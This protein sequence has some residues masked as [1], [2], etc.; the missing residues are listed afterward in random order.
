[1]FYAP[2]DALRK[3]RFRLPPEEEHHAARVLRLDEGA[4]VTVVDGSGEG[5][6]VRLERDGE[7][8]AARVVERLRPEAEPLLRLALAIGDLKGKEVDRVIER[9]T[10]IGAAAFFPYH[11]KRT[12]RSFSGARTEARRARWE[13]V[14]RRAMKVAGA[15]RLPELF[16]ACPIEEVAERAGSFDAAFLFRREAPPL[17]APALKVASVLAVV[18]PEGGLGEGDEKILLDAGLVAAS[19]GPRNLRAGTAAIVAA[20]RL[21]A[22]APAGGGEGRGS[23]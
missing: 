13:R 6:R 1:V 9:A 10:E 3:E 15:A 2:P 8:L 11:A 12:V 21:L 14:A 22:P 17:A 7:R 19:L 5:A 18:G 23:R 16:P 4:E 20:A